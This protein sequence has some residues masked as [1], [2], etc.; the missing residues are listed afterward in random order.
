MALRID[1]L[2]RLQMLIE[3]LF[4]HHSSSFPKQRNQLGMFEGFMKVLFKMFEAIPM[5]THG[6]YSFN[7]IKK[8]FLGVLGEGKQI[9]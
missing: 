9:R 6:K 3:L 2:H 5:R 7:T 1:C 4:S 8:T